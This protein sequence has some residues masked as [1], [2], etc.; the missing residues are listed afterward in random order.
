VLKLP[1]TFK[2]AKVGYSEQVAA[3]NSEIARRSP[4]VLLRNVV[5]FFRR[6]IYFDSLKIRDLIA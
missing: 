3:F 4:R 5:P 6:D 1:S 2:L